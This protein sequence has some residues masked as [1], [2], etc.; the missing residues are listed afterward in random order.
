MTKKALAC[1]AA[2]IYFI[3]CTSISLLYLVFQLTLTW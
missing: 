3:L 2:L 1:S